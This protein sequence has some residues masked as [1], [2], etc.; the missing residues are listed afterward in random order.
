MQVENAKSR[1]FEHLLAQQIVSSYF[2]GPEDETEPVE[3]L[4]PTSNFGEN[5]IIKEKKKVIE[6]AKRY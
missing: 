4:N 1:L 3:I 5:I 2:I 6:E